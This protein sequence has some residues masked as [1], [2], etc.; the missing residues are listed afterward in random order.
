M[1]AESFGATVNFEWS[2]LN[3]TARIK[4]LKFKTESKVPISAA[5]HPVQNTKLYFVVFPHILSG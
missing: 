5:S 4:H 1:M 2:H 3:L